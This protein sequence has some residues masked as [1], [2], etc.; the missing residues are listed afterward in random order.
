MRFFISQHTLMMVGFVIWLAP[1][2]RDGVPFD[3]E[4]IRHKGRII[5]EAGIRME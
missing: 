2:M 4:D 3:R 1:F 5:R